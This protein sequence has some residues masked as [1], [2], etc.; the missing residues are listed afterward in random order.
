MP[1]AI[2]RLHVDAVEP[3]SSWPHLADDEVHLWLEQ[4][5][6]PASAREVSAFGRQRL[7][8]LLR[9]YSGIDATPD[10]MHNE[11]GK[12]QPGIDCYPRFNISHAGPMLALGFA[13]SMEIGVD[14][15]NAQRSMRSHELASRFFTRAEADALAEFAEPLRA[16]GFMRL[17]TCKEAVLKAIGRGLS[18]GLDRLAFDFNADAWPQSLLHIAD[19]AGPASDWQLHQFEV[20]ATHVGSLAW[21]GPPRRIRVLRKP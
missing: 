8:Q 16:L 3:G 15:E 4:L 20:D 7:G 10:L 19:E 1:S 12:P 17:W 6:P 14:I 18:F 2:Q 5:A 9:H 21:C 11:H 13:R